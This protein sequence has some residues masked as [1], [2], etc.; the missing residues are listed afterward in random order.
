MSQQI[1][2]NREE[3]GEG[4][5]VNM[6]VADAAGIQQ[7]NA[8]IEGT[9]ENQQ[10]NVN[11]KAAGDFI[12]SVL[13]IIIGIYVMIEALNMKVFRYFIDAPGLFPLI[14][15]A[16]L[17]VLGA[18]LAIQSLKNGAWPA[19]KVV[20][21]KESVKD[22]IMNDKTVRALVL[23]ALMIVY[24]YVL[25]GRV[26]FAIA[27]MLYLTATM[28]YLRATKWWIILII[29]AVATAVICV[30]FQYGFRVPLP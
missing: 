17:T 27:T 18:I 21:S 22:F 19:L 28:F 25:I 9:G 30:A 29:S 14:L 8:N 5:Q 6:N 20:F 1:D 10:G 13:L 4:R 7:G 3:A 11:R 2:V 15:G 23:I 16:I 12:I 24:I 26:H